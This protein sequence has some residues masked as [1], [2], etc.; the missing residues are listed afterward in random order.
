MLTLLDLRGAISAFIHN[1]DGK[2]HDVN[3]LDRLAF[4]AGAFYVMDRGYV[5]FARLY[6][7]ASSRCLLRHACQVL[8][9]STAR[10]LYSY[11]S[12]CRRNY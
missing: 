12:K 5:D 8:N 4:E 9:A 10:L 6:A 1:S 7:L 2:L 3:V 11:G